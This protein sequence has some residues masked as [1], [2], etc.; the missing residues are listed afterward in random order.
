MAYILLYLNYITINGETKV[1]NFQLFKKIEVQEIEN[2]TAEKIL[3]RLKFHLKKYYDETAIEIHQNNSIKLNG[4]FCSIF[5]RAITKAEAKINFEKKFVGFSAEGKSSIGIW[6]YIWL[7]IGFFTG[8]GFGVFL[9]LIVAYI[10]A[11]D[12]PK[13]HFEEAFEALKFEIS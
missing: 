5:E 2:W 11:K 7:L 12:K 1:S 3:D 10:I 9:Y 13:S 6:P 4:K 8:F